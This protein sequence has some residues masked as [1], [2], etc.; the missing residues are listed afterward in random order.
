MS[1]TPKGPFDDSSM[2]SRFSNRLANGER[3]SDEE[4]IAL[5]T[6]NNL[7]PFRFAAQSVAGRVRQVT[8]AP[9]LSHSADVA[10]RAA[11]LAYPWKYQ[12]VCLLHDAVEEPA[13]DLE[14]VARRLQIV[15]D[16]FGDEVARDVRELTNR[17]SLIFKSIERK[18]PDRLP[19][20]TASLATIRDAVFRVRR[21]LPEA[22][23]IEFAPDFQFLFD[24]FFDHLLDDV[25][26]DDC[27]KRAR[28]NNRFTI[29][30]EVRH[31]VYGV[32]IIE[33][34]DDAC[35]RIGSE[36]TRFYDRALVAKGLDIVD[37]QRTAPV[38]ARNIQRSINKAEIYLDRCFYLNQWLCDRG[39]TTTT[40]Q[41]LYGFVK[42]HTV[43]QA[44]E[45]RSA[46]APLADE[47]FIP[48][49]EH[50]DKEI[51]RLRKKYCVDVDPIP[52]IA[53]VAEEIRVRNTGTTVTAQAEPGYA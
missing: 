47:R 22:V 24:H 44:I 3:A 37:N 39:I 9:S 14:D 26:L 13:N 25:N 49:T 41:N 30:S 45:R 20:E 40:F 6:E 18:V 11:L 15:Q 46:L 52:E 36:G 50:L 53:R 32:Y 1:D 23:R 43:Q 5:F 21:E 10:L 4:V 29:V 42:L 16:R 31:R 27:K 7:A 19:F 34:A 35:K 2:I 33:L 12:R 48:L 28:L 38:G 17:Y 8:G 51:A